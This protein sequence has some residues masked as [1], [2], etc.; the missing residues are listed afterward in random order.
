M[1]PVMQAKGDPINQHKTAPISGQMYIQP[2]SPGINISSLR[3]IRGRLPEI[4][5][6]FGV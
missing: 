3:L 6:I 2:N 4:F 1:I 5:V